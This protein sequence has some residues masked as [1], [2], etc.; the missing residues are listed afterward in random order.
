[1]FERF[2]TPAPVGSGLVIQPVGQRVLE[3]IGVGQTA[4]D[5][6]APIS[7]MYGA[8]AETGRTVLDVS[9]SRPGSERFGLAIHRA[10]LFDCLIKQVTRA[11][12]PIET[13]SEI[14]GVSDGGRLCLRNESRS[15]R[16]DLI[17]DA[18]GATSPLRQNPGRPLGYGALWGTV[19]WPDQLAL[20]PDMLHQRYKA[21]SHMLGILP[22]GRMPG[23]QKQL[24]SIF[25]SLPSNTYDNWRAAPLERWKAQAA[26]LWPEFRLCLDQITA[27]EQMTMARYMHG[28]LP[29]VWG[30]NVVHI[31]DAAHMASPQLG[32]GA[33]MA[34]LDA[35]TLACA[36]R[37]AG[38]LNWQ[39]EA[40]VRRRRW[41][42]RLYQAMSRA[43]TP[44][45]QSDSRLLPVIRNHVMMP[46]SKVSPMPNLLSRLVCGDLIRPD[47]LK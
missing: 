23:S 17:I 11:N 44:F 43:F 21:A 47:S 38:P 12:I 24:A 29:R 19:E 30:G 25:W 2:E 27:H 36:L 13:S 3:D 45:Y 6:G 20:P 46:L 5:H 32:Q 26:L 28:T 7:R 14:V 22:I 34:L 9:Y 35:D 18:A 4:L 37:A 8:E 41:H 40:F 1:M 10:S 39:L 15:D 16:F 33:N 31:G 42:T